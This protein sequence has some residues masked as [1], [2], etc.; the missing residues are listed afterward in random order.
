MKVWLMLERIIIKQPM[1][2]EVICLEIIV[3][4]NDQNTLI[5]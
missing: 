5:Q 4:T 3:M 2:V 1:I